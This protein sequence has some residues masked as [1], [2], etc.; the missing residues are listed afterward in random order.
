MKLKN[1]YILSSVRNPTQDVSDN[2]F[3]DI[4][5]VPTTSSEELIF[6]VPSSTS[7]AIGNLI[8]TGGYSGA[9]MQYFYDG[10]GVRQNSGFNTSAFEVWDET[11][12][13]YITCSLVED[14]IST[15]EAYL[16]WVDGNGNTVSAVSTSDNNR[17]FSNFFTA[18]TFCS[19]FIWNEAAERFDGVL[20]IVLERYYA[21]GATAYEYTQYATGWTGTLGRA[22][23][24][25]LNN[26]I[27]RVKI[28]QPSEYAPIQARYSHSITKQTDIIL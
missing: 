24:P 18:R 11:S 3:T 6:P 22:P 26:D 21:S 15:R 8:Q 10:T 7:N 19:G 27:S 9:L 25:N 13:Q 12:G 16:Y 4:K 17:V 23:L 14:P 2:V 20:G 1:D 5:Y 28:Q